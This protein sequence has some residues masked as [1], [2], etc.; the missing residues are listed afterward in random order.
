MKKKPALPL[1]A[2]PEVTKPF[3]IAKGPS[4]QIRV[5]QSCANGRDF[6]EL[7][8]WTKDRYSWRPT[9]RSVQISLD[10]VLE[11]FYEMMKI[12]VETQELT[13]RMDNAQEQIGQRV[14]EVKET[15]EKT[16]RELVEMP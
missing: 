14:K 15:L 10:E 16:L 3:T 9:E 4:Q 1:L 6:V 13:K 11:P 8:I 12:M 5:R 2:K 7:Q